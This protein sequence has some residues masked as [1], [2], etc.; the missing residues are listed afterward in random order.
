MSSSAITGVVTFLAGVL[1]L[2]GWAYATAGNPRSGAMLKKSLLVFV[3]PVLVAPWQ[4]LQFPLAMWIWVACEEGLKA[5]A[6]T[7]E[8]NSMNRFWLVSLFGIWELVLDKPVVL[9]A[10]VAQ[11]DSTWA[12][13]QMLGLV[14]TAALPVLMH[15]V[16]AA[17]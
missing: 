5:F 6:S 2:L 8:R 4:W 10:I 14:Y 3:V 11:S 16:T 17:I 15:T 9:W 1:L 7:Q 12:Q 13:P